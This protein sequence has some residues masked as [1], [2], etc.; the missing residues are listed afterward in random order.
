MPI[1]LPQLPEKFCDDLILAQFLLEKCAELGFPLPDL[2]AGAEEAV[3]RVELLLAFVH[4][5]RYGLKHDKYPK[6][7]TIDSSKWEP[8][9]RG[10][11]R[12]PLLDGF[13]L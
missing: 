11:G 4:L 5:C 10:L 7:P 9:I 8:R 2:L 6:Q 3:E 1:E 12:R 13:L